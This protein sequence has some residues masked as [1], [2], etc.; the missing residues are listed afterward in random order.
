MCGAYGDSNVQ[1][2]FYWA[3]AELYITNGESDDTGVVRWLHL[4]PPVAGHDQH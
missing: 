3:A 2:E 1:D 4:K